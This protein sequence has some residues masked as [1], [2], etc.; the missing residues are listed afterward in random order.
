MS[1]SPVPA[2]LHQLAGRRFS[3]YPP[4]RGVDHNE[5]IYRRASWSEVVVVNAKTGAECVIPRAHIGEV[6]RI[7]QP[8]ALV[9]LRRELE[10]QAG[11]ARV[12]H[13][14]I[15]ELPVAVNQR[16]NAIPHPDFP[17]QVVSIRLEPRRDARLRSRLV[18]GIVLG[19]IGALIAANLTRGHLN[20]GLSYDRTVK[21][22]D[23]REYRLIRY[24]NRKSIVVLDADSHYVG[25]LD[26]QRHVLDA[27]RLPGGQSAAP[28]LQSLPLF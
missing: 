3:F 18:V 9:A 23:G 25:T 24:R 21:G 11:S 8:V 28:L 17:A 6:S 10:A 12:W 2:T 22:P 13:K 7:E 19:A 5:W 1:L 27:A 4:L 15:V 20:P 26:T 16:G 14:P